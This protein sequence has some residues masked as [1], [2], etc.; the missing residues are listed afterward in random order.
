MAGKIPPDAFEYYVVAES[1]AAVAEEFGVSKRAVV[2]YAKK[3][4]WQ[5]RLKRIR[6]RVNRRIDHKVT[7]T[8]EA[9]NERHLKTMRFIQGKAIEALRSTPIASVSDAIRALDLAIKQERLI[10]GESQQPEASQMTGVLVVPAP[11]SPEDWVAQQEELNKTR[12]CP[13]PDED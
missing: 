12:V 6:E 10:R 9:M 4:S 3:H 7:E 5:A 8:L 1:Y 2:A 13:V 11:M